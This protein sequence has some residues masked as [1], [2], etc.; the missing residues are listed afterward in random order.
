MAIAAAVVGF[1]FLAS[2]L[3]LFVYIFQGEGLRNRGRKSQ[4][5]LDVTSLLP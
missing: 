4:T 5:R 1:V 2:G 3:G